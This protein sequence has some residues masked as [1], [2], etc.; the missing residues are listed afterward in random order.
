MKLKHLN[1]DFTLSMNFH[2]R[3]ISWYSKNKR[4]LPW[5]IAPEPYKVWLSEIIMQQTRI[6]QGT[7]YYDR[8]IAHYPNVKSLA[9]ASEDEVLKLWQGLG[10]YSRARN[11]HHAARQ[12]VS[13]Y[14]GRFPSTYKE[15]LGLKGVGPYSAAAIASICYGEP[16]PVVDGNVYR[17]LARH[18]AIGTPIDSTEG[19]KEFYKKALELIDPD[20]PGDFNQAMMEF[21]A[22]VCTPHNPRCTECPFRKTCAAYA[23][24]AVDRYPVK[25]KKVK[26]QPLHIHYFV[27]RKQG[28]IF[29]KQRPSDGIWGGLHEFPMV[30]SPEK[31]SKS[32]LEKSASE[33]GL[34][35]LRNAKKSQPF[36][37]LL[38]HRRITAH[39]WLF[40]FPDFSPKSDLI[41][42]QSPEALKNTAVP[43]LIDRYLQEHIFS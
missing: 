4:N 40:D 39:F 35:A 43:R 18:F 41:F 9:D 29:L 25:A 2:K 26:T 30:S 12:V 15:L 3:L 10:Y 27:I 37:H 7:P 13:E 34:P 42:V 20:R 14:G 11:L 23:Q 38:T 36:T 24:D 31:I 33:I 5:R 22:T 6:D 28:G 16:I 32:T 21:G 1:T 8:F 19:K 17:F